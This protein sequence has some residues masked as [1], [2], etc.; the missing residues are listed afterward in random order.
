MKLQSC[1][2]I[3]HPKSFLAERI[4]NKNRFSIKLGSEWTY[5]TI[6]DFAMLICIGEYAASLRSD[7][8]ANHSN[9]RHAAT[10][11]LNADEAMHIHKVVSTQDDNMICYC[12]LSF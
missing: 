12:N 5:K 11:G 4:K 9:F 7:S 8:L 10:C 6:R 2:A 3:K 1:I